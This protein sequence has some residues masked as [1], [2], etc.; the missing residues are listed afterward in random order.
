MKKQ[1]YLSVLGKKRESEKERER[2]REREGKRERE[3]DKERER[4]RERQTE[5]ETERKS[6][7]TFFVQHVVKGRP[8]QFSTL[9][10][11]DNTRPAGHRNVRSANPN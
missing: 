2:K 5:R 6:M 1:R 7:I 11:N 9:L 4:Q 3:S 8:P 10:R